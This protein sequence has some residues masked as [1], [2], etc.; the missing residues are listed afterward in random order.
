MTA[1][2]NKLVFVL[3]GGYKGAGKNTVVDET[4][5]RLREAHPQIH[6]HDDMFARPIKEIASN[7]FRWQE[8]DKGVIGRALL[9]VIGDKLRDVV[10]DV[11]DQAQV[12]NPDMTFEQIEDE[13]SKYF[14][15]T[16]D[17]N[18]F[19]ESLIDRSISNYP[20]AVV[21]VTDVRM[22]EEFDRFDYEQDFR[23]WIHADWAKPSEHV[24][25]SLQPFSLSNVHHI[26]NVRDSDFAVRDLVK[27][28]EDHL[29]KLG[30]PM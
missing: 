10:D 4:M 27:K 3:V 25:E 16:F 14:S 29:I 11:M 20:N 28:I 8:D 9:Q 24:T 23:V 19:I 15:G 30:Y 12:N 13:A 26:T 1:Y 21:F 7:Y 22:L 2:K 6:F 5:R 17:Y 18:P